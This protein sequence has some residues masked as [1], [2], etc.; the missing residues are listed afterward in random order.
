MIKVSV[1]PAN[2]SM[3]TGQQLPLGF[4]DE[5]VTGTDQHVD[6][7]DAPGADGHGANLGCR[8]D[9]NLVGAGQRLGGDDGGAGCR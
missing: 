4:G 9:K 6:A 3:P 2:K 7:G 8:R 5:S 1:G